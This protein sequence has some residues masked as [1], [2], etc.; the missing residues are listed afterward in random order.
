MC[1]EFGVKFKNKTSTSI[2]SANNKLMIAIH[3]AV[4]WLHDFCIILQLCG[5]SKNAV[6]RNFMLWQCFMT[7]AFVCDSALQ[8]VKNWR[9]HFVWCCY[10]TLVTVQSVQSAISTV[11]WWFKPFAWCCNFTLLPVQEALYCLFPV[12]CRSFVTVAWY[13][14]FAILAV[15]NPLIGDSTSFGTV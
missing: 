7:F 15:Q 5:F 8:A 12:V 2:I 13:C 9:F 14:R 1:R 11:R 3:M 4:S 10:F 6:F